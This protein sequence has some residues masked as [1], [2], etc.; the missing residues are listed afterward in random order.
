[1]DL[2]DLHKHAE[3]I[4]E[5]LRLRTHPLAIKMLKSEAEIPEEAHK[6]CKRYGEPLGSLSRF[7]VGKILC[8]YSEC[9][10]LK[11]GGS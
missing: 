8:R 3:D 7:F 4:M 5:A 1:V 2:K 10:L 6:T 11:P 9:F